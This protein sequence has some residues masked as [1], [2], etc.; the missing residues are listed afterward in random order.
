MNSTQSSLGH[1]ICW[2][3]PPGSGKRHALQTQLQLW[4]KSMGQLYVLKRQFWDAPLQ[5]GEMQE[6]GDEVSSDEK[7]L[8]PMEVSILHWGF[9]VAR[10]SLQDKQYIKSILLRWGRGS[11]VLANSG[12]SARC[13]VLYHAHLLSSESIL[14]LQAFLEENCH[15]TILWMTSEHPLPPRL[16]D[17]CIELPVGSKIDRNLEKLQFTPGIPTIQEEI[18]EIYKLWMES[19]PTLSDV[20]KIRSVVYGLLHR[21]I[22]WTDGFHHWMFALD[23]L[24][25]T[26]DQKARVADVCIRQ[27]FTG[28]GQTVPSYR[29]PILWENYLLCL[30]QALAPLKESDSASDNITKPP[31]KIT[32]RKGKGVSKDAPTCS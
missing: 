7:A 5:G 26:L 25:L 32:S 16:A 29:I 22:R 21:N 20:K 15:D 19:P 30:R 6:D 18:V 28:P 2:R 4:A 31:K 8:L 3:G 12:H 1:S 11:Q 13:L 24:P 14:F 9:D 27:P 17:W 10:M 23:S